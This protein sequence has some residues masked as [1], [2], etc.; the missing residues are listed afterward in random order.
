MSKQR[1]ALRLSV[2]MLLS[3]LL[4]G[5]MQPTVTPQQAPQD[6]RTLVTDVQTMLNGLGYDAGAPDGV[7]GPRTRAALSA[8][9][10]DRGLSRTEGVT[11]EAYA[12]LANAR[13]GTAPA[14]TAAASPSR[15]ARPGQSREAQEQARRRELSR[16]DRV[17]TFSANC[18]GLYIPEVQEIMFQR[19]VPAYAMR[20]LNN[21]DKRYRISYDITYMERGRNYFGNTGGTFT[22]ERNLVS[23]A[24]SFAE[25]MIMQ[26]NKGSGTVVTGITKINVFSCTT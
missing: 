15:G 24:G 12:Q 14:A 26:K 16:N 13:A 21:S 4:L 25:F 9:Q 7:A 1:C 8:F 6:R 2:V 18:P 22:L 19:A 10:R 23:R 20:V 5:C 17:V 3:L 11:A